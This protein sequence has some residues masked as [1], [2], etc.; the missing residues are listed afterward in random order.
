MAS[1]ARTYRGLKIQR[2]PV[3]RFFFFV[4]TLLKFIFIRTMYNNIGSAFEIPPKIF[5]CA[6][7]S[8]IMCVQY[9]V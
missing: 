9:D 8:A 5:L 2:S 6:C 1:D 4:Y 3:K 7:L